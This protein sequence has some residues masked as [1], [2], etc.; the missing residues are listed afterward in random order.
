MQDEYLVSAYKRCTMIPDVVRFLKERLTAQPRNIQEGDKARA[1]VLIPLV[2]T[3][4]DL[5]MLLTKRTEKVELHKGQISF[6]GGAADTNDANPIET[7]LRESH[8]EIGISPTFIDIVG[9]MDDFNAHDG[10]IITPVVGYIERLPSLVPNPAEVEEIFLVPLTDFL[11]KTKRQS[12][13]MQRGDAPVEV[14]FYD[15]WKEPVWGITAFLIKQLTDIL[16]SSGN[17]A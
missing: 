14:F 11:D 3:T 15:V 10:F 4:S 8:E 2:Q 5:H 17:M 16:G 7:A 1:S 6:P 12:K 9:M 13:I